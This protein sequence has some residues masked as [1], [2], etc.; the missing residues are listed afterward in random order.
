MFLARGSVVFSE[1]QIGKRWKPYL[2]RVKTIKI[3]AV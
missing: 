1:V 3:T 2:Y